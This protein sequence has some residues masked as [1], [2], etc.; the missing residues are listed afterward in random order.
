MM[1]DLD[2]AQAKPVIHYYAQA[3][4][5]RHVNRAASSGL[6][7]KGND[8]TLLFWKHLSVGMEGDYNGAIRELESLRNKR[9]VEFPVTAALVHIHK[10]CARKDYDAISA[11]EMQLE[12]CEGSA[13]ENSILLAARFYWQVGEHDDARKLVDKILPE[14]SNRNPIQSAAQTLRGWIDLTITPESMREEDLQKNS[15]RFFDAPQGDS[16]ELECIM[17]RAKFYEVNRKYSN[18]LDC[19]NQAVVLH[20]W[21]EPALFE[22]AKVLM[23][24]GDWEQAVETANRVLNINEHE[25]ESLNIVIL[26]N[27]CR[28]ANAEE[29]AAKISKLIQALDRN[30]S[31]NPDLYFSLSKPYSKICGRNSE[32]LRLTQTLIERAMRLAPEN[33]NYAAEYGDQLLLQHNYDA[34]MDAFKSAAKMDETNVNA[35]HGMIRCQIMDQQLEDAAQQIEFL[36]VI[37]DGD[38][39]MQAEFSFL[40]AKLAWEKEADREK[41]VQ[42]LDE[43]LKVQK[44]YARAGVT[45]SS[46]TTSFTGTNDSPAQ[47]LACLD[48]DFMLQ[49]ARD[50]MVHC[51]TEPMSLDQ[52]E[53]AAEC[54]EKARK[55][56]E[57]LTQ[58]VPGLLEA[59]LLLA[60]ARFIGN[61]I[62]AAQRSISKLLQMEPS[63]AAAHLLNARVH[64]AQEKNKAAQQSL[65]QAVSHDFT[66][67][68]QPVFQLVKAKILENSNDL[69][70]A[71]KVLTEAMELPG[72][73]KPK[74]Q[75]KSNFGMAP[76]APVT[77]HDRVSLFIQL[78]EVNTKL[79]K[80]PEATKVI[81]EALGLFRG[82][83]EEV[84]VVVANSQLAIKRN[85]FGAAVRML[86]AVPQDSV[87][88]TKAQLVKAN[89][90]LTH[91]NDKR[92]FIN[93]YQA[94]VDQNDSSASHIH[95]GEAYMRIQE[96]EKAIEC[97]ERALQLN[98][99]DSALATKI[100]VALVSTHDYLKAIDYY[101]TALRTAPERQDLRY[102]LAELYFKLQEYT[103]AIR[104]L[105][106][107]LGHGSSDNDIN[108]MKSE[109]KGHMLLADIH[110]GAKNTDKVTETLSKA[111]EKQ[112]RVM[113]LLRSGGSEEEQVQRGIAAMI[114]FKMAQ[115][116]ETEQDDEKA[117]QFYN[118]ALRAQDSHT[119][120]ILALAKLHLRKGELE[121]AQ[122]QCVTLMRI[123]SND[124]EPIMML[125]DLMC[126]R[127]DYD[128]ATFHFQQILERKP[129]NYLALSKL[130]LLL[131]RAGKLDQAPNFLKMAEAHSPRAVHMPGLHYCKG[132]HE[133]Y[134]NNIHVAVQNFNK[135]R[136][137]GE[138]GKQAIMHMVEIYLNPDNENMWEETEGQDTSDAVRV[139]EKLMRELPQRPK[140]LRHSVLECYALMAT[141][142]KANIE[143]AI[144]KFIALLERERDY[145][146]ALLGMATAFMMQKQ[147]PKARNQLKR[148]S[149]M[150][151][152]K[153]MA[154]DFEQSYLLLADIYIQR[155]K[156]DLAQELCKRCLGYNRSCAKAWEYMGLVMEKEQSYRDAADHYEQAWKFEGEASATVGYKLAFNYLKA[157]RYVEAINVCHKVISMYPD[158][159]KIRRDILDKAR[160]SLRN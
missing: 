137:D 152:D 143:D 129:N 3:K 4:W 139:A 114:C 102:S 82:T 99:S 73:K 119:K 134:S 141:Q 75:P 149:K 36:T 31:S 84:R 122:H 123:D 32:I 130:I 94:M 48:P 107:S 96:P 35:L 38:S 49:I 72:V 132:L 58:Q 89:I 100:G 117:L 156:F 158:Y 64:L 27:L 45:K 16:S 131:R 24:M 80:V 71:L 81:Q 66:C 110:V 50:Y 20:G 67:R 39:E 115:F 55:L 30:E 14:T 78:A 1:S 106:Q 157:R 144:Q 70:G 90:Y 33:S 120:S 59:K 40:Q 108:S 159:P 91:R 17:G 150:T 138:W 77:M 46:S 155:G 51:G 47:R 113:D 62:E 13:S 85:D 125:A 11:L 97:F 105:D 25:I 41:Q 22:K 146:P 68:S 37:Q 140:S 54:L 42:L 18:A 12:T 136:R 79:N 147:M 124:D 112:Q 142:N 57:D 87:A 145:V 61:D 9:D 7:R 6:S 118:E 26:Y 69:E 65:E 86:S 148:I 8:T 88:Y 126:R 128:T 56:L 76:S 53:F 127:N 98:P 111:R 154:D 93:C 10:M 116:Y 44:E 74:V 160:A 121:R 151:F 153:E 2:P 34:A 15:I 133:R 23:L 92:R 52:G 109:V 95:L 60:N 83:P 19:L 28:E 21:F 103:R 5:Y 29:A 63:F 135:A 104:V 101:E 43:A